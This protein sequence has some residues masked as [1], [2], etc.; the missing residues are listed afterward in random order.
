MPRS[1]RGRGASFR[2]RPRPAGEKGGRPGRLLTKGVSV[3]G[4]PSQ[5]PGP[6]APCGHRHHRAGYRPSSGLLAIPRRRG[7][8]PA[9]GLAT[10]PPAHDRGRLGPPC[11]RGRTRRGG[12][13]QSAAGARR[14]ARSPPRAK[15]RGADWTDERRRSEEGRRRVK[16]ARRRAAANRAPGGE[17]DKQSEWD[18]TDSHWLRASTSAVSQ[19]E[20]VT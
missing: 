19:I 9:R 13:P 6:R 18:S 3:A 12:R 10:A 2:D 11:A 20:T 1:T 14:R 16:S 8:G 4:A 7:A 5:E 15:G 17:Q